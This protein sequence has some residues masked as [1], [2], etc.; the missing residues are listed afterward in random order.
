MKKSTSKTALVA[1]IWLALAFIFSCSSDNNDSNGGSSLPSVDG[2]TSSSSRISS[3]S[4][5]SSSSSGSSS[6]NR[7]SSSSSS[8]SYSSGVSSSTVDSSSSRPSSSSVVSSSSVASSSSSRPSSS[9][10]VS[11]S[12]YSPSSSSVASSSSSRSSSSSVA[13]SSSIQT[14]IINGT[15]VTY[16]G[17]TYQTVVIGTQTWFKRNLNYNASGSKC[18][19]NK[20]SNCDIY[21][22]LY[23]WA[24]AMALPSNCNSSFCTSQIGTKHKGICPSGW[25]IPS[26]EDWSVLMKFVNPSC[27]DNNCVGAG[28]KLKAADG[29]N[30]YNSVKGTDDY[31]FSALPGG[32]GDSGGF[33]YSVGDFGNWWSASEGNSNYAYYRRMNYGNDN[34]NWDFNGKYSMFSVRCLQD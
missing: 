13:S 7:S 14:G 33:F 5:T 31:G 23:D 26:D 6:S 30:S 15:P 21:G 22:R 19:D 3:S 34:A 28:T 18:Y 20:E 29:W 8:T 11:S 25:H 17:E 32:N 10:V 16:N 1:T 2:S 12:S 24:T 27:S 4:R 9:S